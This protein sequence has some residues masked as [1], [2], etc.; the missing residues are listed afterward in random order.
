MEAA[1]NSLSLAT[2]KAR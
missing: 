1:Q 2:W